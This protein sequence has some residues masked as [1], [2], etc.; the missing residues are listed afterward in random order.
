MKPC[1][2]PHKTW[3]N[4]TFEIMALKTLCKVILYN[5]DKS[6]QS[7]QPSL[8][9]FHFDNGVYISDDNKLHGNNNSIYQDLLHCKVLH[10]LIPKRKG[11]RSDY[12]INIAIKKCGVK[13]DTNKTTFTHKKV[14]R[15]MESSSTKI[16]AQKAERMKEKRKRVY[17]GI[18]FVEKIA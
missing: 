1:L 11:A 7:D 10:Y 3:P 4:C 12:I 16:Q 15:W 13:K 17:I 2:R 5:Q 6:D 9:S 8:T 18:I 14:Q